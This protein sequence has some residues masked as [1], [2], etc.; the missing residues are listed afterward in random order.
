MLQPKMNYLGITDL[1]LVKLY[2]KCKY[3]SGLRHIEGFEYPV[4][5]GLACGV[6]P[7][8]FDRK[9]TRQ[10]FGKY[11][12]FVEECSGS[13]LVDQLKTILGGLRYLSVEDEERN[14]VLREF[15]WLKIAGGFWR[16]FNDVYS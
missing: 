15:D 9:E 14:V 10:W 13:R 12:L 1:E 2:S 11:A 5:E 3:V 7:I 6:R 8:V 4:I 16:M